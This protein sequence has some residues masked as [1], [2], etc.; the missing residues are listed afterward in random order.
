[1]DVVTAAVLGGN[2]GGGE[3]SVAGAIIGTILLQMLS[4]ALVLF[5]VSGDGQNIIKGCLIII[6]LIVVSVLKKDQSS[7]SASK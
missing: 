1:M 2:I 7:I 4:S 3:G 5:N 6:G